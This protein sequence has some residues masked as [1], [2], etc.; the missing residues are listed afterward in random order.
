MKVKQLLKFRTPIEK[1]KARKLG[2][3]KRE[4][5]SDEETTA[6]SVR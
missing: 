6:N 3:T 5:K 4:S 1:I 2:E